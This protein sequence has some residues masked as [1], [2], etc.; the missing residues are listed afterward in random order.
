M[1]RASVII[2]SWNGEPHLGD[3]LRAILAQAGPDDQVIVADNGSADGSTTLVREQFPQV[4]LIASERHLGLAGG[5]NAGLR[6]AQGAYLLLVSQDVTL[7]AGWLGKMIEALTP[8]EV[9]IA[10]CKLLHPDGTIQHAGGITSFPLALPDCQEMGKGQ[11]DT[12]REVDYVTG[13]AMGLK[14]TVLD[15]IGLFDESFFPA[16][17]EETDLCFRA[18]AAGYQIIY[19]PEATGTHHET[20]AIDRK[21][22]EYHRWMNRGRLRFMLKHYT[23][24]QFHEEF[25]PAEEVWQAGLNELALCQGLRQAYLDTV[26]DLQNVPTGG[27]LTGKDSERAVAE[28][29]LGLRQALGG[30]PKTG[31]G[32]FLVEPPWHIH[33]SK[34]P[35]IARLRGLLASVWRLQEKLAVIQEILASMDHELTTT[36]R[37]QAE[38]AAGLRE[39]IARLN[40]RVQA[41]EEASSKDSE[42]G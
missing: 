41:L 16:C 35:V 33:R 40:A 39:D 14:R 26:L 9:G 13:A 15:E 3:C 4:H 42:E 17:Y 12:R 38:A 29:L 25:V 37:I 5:Y 11:W 36:R 24:E 31:E 19:T 6:A 8:A 32:A 18:R 23:A 10:G 28:A 21:S 7:K 2:V 30:Q 1:I 22:A 27:V 20:T 34:A